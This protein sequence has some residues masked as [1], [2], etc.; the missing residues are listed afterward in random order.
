MP[1]PF[2]TIVSKSLTEYIMAN[3]HHKDRFHKEIQNAN[4]K[5]IWPHDNDQR[6]MFI[7]PASIGPA[8]ESTWADW[9]NKTRKMLESFY[10]QYHAE[11][12]TPKHEEYLESIKK[13]IVDVR[14]T[15]NIDIKII[16]L[17]GHEVFLIRGLKENVPKA[18]VALDNFIQEL[19]RQRNDQ[20]KISEKVTDFSELAPFKM[21][22]LKMCRVVEKLRRNNP[23][24]NIT[25]PKDGC[26]IMFEGKTETAVV[27][28]KMKMTE[29]LENLTQ[30][31]P[32]FNPLRH[33]FILQAENDILETF[34]AKN[35]RATCVANN[36]V[37]L[38]A[39]TEGDAQRALQFL[40]DELESEQM[41][42]STTQESSVLQDL[43]GAKFIKDLNVD[44]PTALSHFE[45]ETHCLEITGFRDAVRIHKNNLK[46]YVE[47]NATKDDF[48]PLPD[49][50]VA[51]LQSN[52][53]TKEIP[54]SVR[55]SWSYEPT[56]QIVLNGKPKDT[57]EAKQVIE[58][59]I[60]KIVEKS[61]QVSRIGI[62]ALHKDQAFI[63]PIQQKHRCYIKIKDNEKHKRLSVTSP[64]GTFQHP[65]P[66]QRYHLETGQTLI[67]CHGDLTK[68][69]VD[70]IVNAANSQMKHEDG[71]AGAIVNAGL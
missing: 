6:K 55:I 5:Y 53:D 67:I 24:V 19:D 43:A 25:I 17:K 45:N 51:Y 32:K 58:D 57:E 60:Q 59:H 65:R 64:T 16:V 14:R 61:H 42:F 26:Q 10:N 68:E 27:N 21:K 20:E 23:E 37:K 1:K 49:G 38:T 41:F 52:F 39:E 46:A 22:Q 69:N 31:F 62:L 11:V 63:T 56:P 15:F 48:M 33:Q 30:Q 44:Y 4:A 71:V 40:Q 54:P 50:K 9:E 18:K 34:V 3:K 66:L 29:A 70:G 13:Q 35:I 28:A 12:Y 7:E 36:M 2:I 47:A 8:C